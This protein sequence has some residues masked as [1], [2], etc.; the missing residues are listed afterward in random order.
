MSLERTEGAF[1]AFAEGLL[2]FNMLLARISILTLGVLILAL[3]V[4]RVAF[5]LILGDLH[6]GRR[7]I[8]AARCIVVNQPLQCSWGDRLGAFRRFLRDIFLVFFWIF[9]ILVNDVI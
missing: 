7:V 2:A 4:G 6:S 8:S 1:A 5:P 9:S 3:K